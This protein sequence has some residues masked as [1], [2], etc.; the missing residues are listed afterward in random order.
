MD[1]E[2]VIKVEHVSKVFKLPHEKQSSIKGALINFRKRNKSYEIQEALHD[3]SF[4]VKKGEFFG[5]IGRNGSG[6]SICSNCWPV[7]MRQPLG[8]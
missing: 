4:E 7:Y 3:I 6:K 1:E 8:T 5:I 2:P